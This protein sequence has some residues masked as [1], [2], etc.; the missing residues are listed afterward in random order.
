MS[1]QPM[2][3]GGRGRW[4]SQDLEDQGF[5]PYGTFPGSPTES[6]E[7]SCSIT[8]TRPRVNARIVSDAI[9]GL[10]DGLTVP[11]ALSAGLSA[12][13]NTRVVVVGGLAELVAGAISMGLGGYVGARSEVESYEA[14]VRET[15]HLVKASP[16]ETMNI[17]REVFA[18]YNLPD[19]PVAHMSN[20]LYNSPE[21]LLDFLLTFHHKESKP[22]CNQAWISAITLALGYFIGGFIPLIP[23]FIVDHVLAALYYSIGIMIFT[24]LVFGYVKTCIV[25]GW[26]GRENIVAGIKGGLQMVVVGGLAAGAAIALARAINPTGRAMF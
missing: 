8:S 6:A 2:L 10:S 11:F 18:P 23:Y 17:I 5:A 15:K 20:I 13:G 24:L 12:L 19:E 16:V 4:D 1:D 3:G 9:L 26:A 7:T 22:G 21:K 25:R 14:T